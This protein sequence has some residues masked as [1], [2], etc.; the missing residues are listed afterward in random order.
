MKNKVPKLRFPE[1]SGEWEEKKF[2][3][4]VKINQGLQIAISE[5][6]DSDGVNRYFYITNE[7][8]KKNSEKKYYIENP[9]ESVLCKDDDI[10][11]TRTGNTGQVVTGVNGA[12]HNNFFKIKYDKVITDKR[13][14][15][16]TLT[17]NKIQNMI[18]KLAG[19]STI[20]DLNHGDF[21]KIKSSYPLL[22][23]QE[24]IASFL[25]EV[26]IKIEK[27]EKK[28]ELLSQYKKG[29]M[30]K[31]FSQKLRFKDESGNDYPEW[32]EKRL[33][34]ICSFFSGG[35][36]KST[37][38]RFYQGD[39]PFIG[40]GN[41]SDS[42]AEKFITEEALNSS[43]SKLVKKGD[44]LYALYGA[45]SGEVAL[46]KIAGA[47]NQ[48]VLCIRSCENIVF[49]YNFFKLN[50]RVILDTYLQGGQGNLSAQIIK[51]LEINLP[52]L[53]EQE[54]IANFLSTID[55]KI[56]LVKEE[57]EKNKEFKKGL[58]Q[59]MFV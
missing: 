49:I 37:E 23:E 46:S 31:L 6:Y 14:L 19:A 5:R 48:A 45:T 10:L 42:F 59:Q 13:F 56:E 35:T 30:Q 40:S 52:S 57:S 50:K 44:L 33:G 2:R 26:D 55:E 24:K 28:K 25:S 9:P 11:M 18:I 53:P 8:L 47:I 1:F 36:P 41:I 43:S 7:F 16:Y 29:M 39:I 27:L 3:E 22:P 17:S 34:E 20:P 32:E 38:K 58:L 15:Y 12:F 21:Y 54:K 4:I 51:E